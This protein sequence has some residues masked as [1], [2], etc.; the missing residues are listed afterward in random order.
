VNALAFW[1]VVSTPDLIIFE[2]TPYLLPAVIA[3]LSGIIMPVS[4]GIL[5]W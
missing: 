5:H 1:I 4:V 3:V 2:D